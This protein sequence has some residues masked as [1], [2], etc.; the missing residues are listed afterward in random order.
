MRKLIIILTTLSIL[1]TPVHAL[2]DTFL[3]DAV[4]VARSKLDIP[5]HYTEFFSG[6]EISPSQ[7]YAFMS[8][9]GDSTDDGV[10]GNIYAEIDEKN[11]IFRYSHFLYGLYDGDYKL[12]SIDYNAAVEIAKAGLARICPE[13]APFVRPSPHK[14]YTARNRDSYSVI[15]YRY[16][17]GIPYYDNYIYVDVLALNGEVASIDAVWHD[18]DQITALTK[19]I[20]I[21]QAKHHYVNKIGLEPGY[22]RR[23]SDNSYFL[24][25]FSRY[26]GREYINA[27]TGELINSGVMSQNVINN[28]YSTTYFHPELNYFSGDTIPGVLSNERLE[29]YL[30]SLLELGI[31][32]KFSAYWTEYYTDET[33]SLYLAI[34]FAANGGRDRCDVIV[35]TA[36]KEIVY[37]DC[38]SAEQ[39]E[40]SFKND[41]QC[42]EIARNYINTYSPDK[43]SE[44]AEPRVFTRGYNNVYYVS[45]IRRANGLLLTDNGISVG[46]NRLTGNIEHY[47]IR[48][49]GNFTLDS[50]VDSLPLDEAW[51][52]IDDE[53]GFELQYIAAAKSGIANPR[54]TDDLQL[55]LVYNLKIGKPVFVDGKTGVLTLESG[56]PYFDRFAH[57]FSDTKDHPLQNQIETLY[58]AGILEYSDFFRPD[59]AITQREFFAFAL[60][61]AGEWYDDDMMYDIL[62]TKGVL[63]SNERDDNAGVTNEQGIMY[64]MRILGYKEIAEL[65]DTYKTDFIDEATID[66]NLIGYAAIAKGKGIFKGN[67]FMPKA[68][69]TRAVAAEIM[70]NLVR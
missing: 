57:I 17:N 43:L 37:Y 4:S 70:Y 63:S 10:G 13:F 33:G 67:A 26:S 25:Y 55:M 3:S 24:Q 23:E 32:D 31:T 16:A 41:V 8:W 6:V 19:V 14:N 60:S 68:V 11:R 65:K 42:L 54:N 59:E 51:Q 20:P 48:W 45:F 7:R 39:Y 18:I 12:S 2:E 53:I 5:E 49:N 61:A 66:P 1:L 28:Y 58:Y 52:V 22:R 50:T 35:N 47:G 56:T 40:G 69:L 44:C 29:F 46:I 62:Y 36:N 9:S 34:S 38:V 21:E 64:I 15:F 30:R 27:Y